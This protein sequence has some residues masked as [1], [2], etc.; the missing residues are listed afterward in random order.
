M[1]IFFKDQFTIYWVLNFW[2]HQKF[3]F[4]FK[5]CYSKS[6]FQSLFMNFL[7]KEEFHAIVH[8]K[9][10]QETIYLFCN[11]ILNLSL[12]QGPYIH[13]CHIYSFFLYLDLLRLDQNHIIWHQI[14]HPIIY[15]LALNLGELCS[16]NGGIAQMNTPM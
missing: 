11:H 1:I 8:I 6:N 7:R 9:V 14:Y 15:F 4:K 5:F 2:F 16:M 3:N 10:S 13:K 12:F